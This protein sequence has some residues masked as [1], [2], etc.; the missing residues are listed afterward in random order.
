ME[1]VCWNLGLSKS[2][3]GHEDLKY[4]GLNVYENLNVNF[5]DCIYPYML[6]IMGAIKFAKSRRNTL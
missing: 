6:Y 5:A 1:I 2:M 4:H 3:M